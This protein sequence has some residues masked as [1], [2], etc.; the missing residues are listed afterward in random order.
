M[1]STSKK[2]TS[3]KKISHQSPRPTTKTSSKA[4]SKKLSNTKSPKK[5]SNTISTTKK[6]ANNQ[7]FDVSTLQ[8]SGKNASEAISIAA[9]IT[10]NPESNIPLSKLKSPCLTFEEFPS[11]YARQWLNDELSSLDMLDEIDDKTR[12]NINLLLTKNATLDRSSTRFSEID[13]DHLVCLWKEGVWIDCSTINAILKLLNEK[14]Q[15][16]SF[17]DLIYFHYSYRYTGLLSHMLPKPD[18]SDRRKFS[19]PNN[20]TFFDYKKIILPINQEGTHWSIC[21]ID[22]DAKT[23]VN[24]NSLPDLDNDEEVLRNMKLYIKYEYEYNNKEPPDEDE[25]TTQRTP[26]L[27]GLNIAHQSQDDCGIFSI[28][29]CEAIS[30][31]SDIEQITQDFIKQC[32]IRSKLTMLLLTLVEDNVLTTTNINKK[33]SRLT[34]DVIMD[35]NQDDIEVK[36]NELK[37]SLD[38][39]ITLDDL[40]NSDL[41]KEDQLYDGLS[42]TDMSN[43]SHDT[44]ECFLIPPEMEFGTLNITK[45]I[46]ST[47]KTKYT[48]GILFYNY[49]TFKDFHPKYYMKEETVE[50]TEK[51]RKAAEFAINYKYDDYHFS[52]VFSKEKLALLF[53]EVRANKVWDIGFH[54]GAFDKMNDSYCLC[55]MSDEF[56]PSHDLF[57]TEDICINCSHDFEGNINDPSSLVKHCCDEQSCH[58]H[59]SIYRYILELYKDYWT[60]SIGHYAVYDDT[61][62]RDHYNTSKKYEIKVKGVNINNITAG[63]R[64]YD[65]V[66]RKERKEVLDF[67]DKEPEIAGVHI[68]RKRINKRSSDDIKELD[69]DRKSRTIMRRQLNI[70]PNLIKAQQPE[71]KVDTSLLSNALT[72]QLQLTTETPIKEIPISTKDTLV[73][74][75]SALSI[76][77][78]PTK[79]LK[80]TSKS[81]MKDKTDKV[82][83]KKKHHQSDMDSSVSSIS[84]KNEVKKRK[85]DEYK[86]YQKKLKI[87]RTEMKHQINH[88]SEKLEVITGLHFKTRDEL[89]EI[90]SQKKDASEEDRKMSPQKLTVYKDNAELTGEEFQGLFSMKATLEGQTGDKFHIVKEDN[91]SKIQSNKSTDINKECGSV[92]SNK[93]KVTEEYSMEVDLEEPCSKGARKG[94][95][96]SSLHDKNPTAIMKIDK[97]AKKNR[98]KKSRLRKKLS[99]SV[100]KKLIELKIVPE[101]V[102]TNLLRLF[103]TVRNKVF[104]GEIWFSLPVGDTPVEEIN[105]T[106]VLWTIYIQGTRAKTI[107]LM[108]DELLKAIDLNKND[109]FYNIALFVTDE[110]NIESTGN[111]KTRD[112]TSSYYSDISPPS[113]I[114]FDSNTSVLLSQGL[115]DTSSEDSY[116]SDISSPKK[117][118][119]SKVCSSCKTLKPET[120]FLSTVSNLTKRSLCDLESEEGTVCSKCQEDYIQYRKEEKSSKLLSYIMKQSIHTENLSW[121]MDKSTKIF[122]K[123]IIDQFMFV[124]KIKTDTLF[125]SIYKSI[126]IHILNIPSTMSIKKY[127]NLTSSLKGSKMTYDEDMFIDKKNSIT[128]PKDNLIGLI[129]FEDTNNFLMIDRVPN[130]LED[131]VKVSKNETKYIGNLETGPR[132]GAAGGF[133]QVG[134]N[135]HSLSQVTQKQNSILLSSKK[136]VSVTCAYENDKGETK[137]YSSVYNDIFMKRISKREKFKILLEDPSYRNIC[138]NEM[139]SRLQSFIIAKQLNLNV[140]GCEDIFKTINGIIKEYEESLSISAFIKLDHS[141]FEAILLDWACSSGEMRNHTAVHAHSDGNVHHPIESL[142]LFA[143]MPISSQPTRENIKLFF[144]AGY[145]YFPINGIIIKY[146]VG[147]H[148][149][150]CNLKDTLHLPD[151]SRD[152]KNWSKVNGP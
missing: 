89:A 143:R 106:N 15:K 1:S 84:A 129:V 47:M 9:S 22:I 33:E 65:R 32:D 130:R 34:V 139:M 63:S 114:L 144:H 93:R 28:L 116:Q 35:K 71:Y 109:L 6:K 111:N 37:I 133:V 4:S 3:S 88:L 108:T 8:K 36:L 55:P 38:Y 103:C 146:R 49:E 58:L 43:C 20:R 17:T 29:F 68:V 115:T 53:E 121:N 23:I 59:Q 91:A 137:K 132:S 50:W 145:L 79:S 113:S 77:P 69:N 118:E 120:Y 66:Y 140:N 127:K 30:T 41:I 112:I 67:P 134:S 31:Q 99:N 24:Y 39:D 87:E 104:I 18:K 72:N 107:T 81:I 86:K 74:P 5:S 19:Y 82:R 90:R 54:I 62:N 11:N 97:T 46:F 52:R 98:N 78:S 48:P 122:N 57:G 101:F 60:P 110:T 25:W 7:P 147:R 13:Y 151:H 51:K 56:F 100:L 96:T 138:I 21:V 119:I 105:K 141:P 26:E 85:N 123:S 16:K 76:I 14:E 135:S 152:D 124:D 44:Y 75:L 150:H 40:I 102:K 45:D 128:M 148:A 61:A 126:Y 64:K 125:Q 83:K 95:Y 12:S 80:D 70:L 94:N 2:K 92:S 117:V 136:S 149:I 10:T 27:Q 73:S 131:I 42:E 142:T